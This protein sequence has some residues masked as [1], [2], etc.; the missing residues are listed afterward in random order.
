MITIDSVSQKLTYMD[1]RAFITN[2][3]MDGDFI[4][5]RKGDGS[6]IFLSPTDFEQIDD[7]I[8]ENDIITIMETIDETSGGDGIEIIT[9]G[10]KYF[11]QIL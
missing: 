8:L 4:L 7:N 10:N 1:L 3:E 6:E 11:L 9:T 2:A 5:L